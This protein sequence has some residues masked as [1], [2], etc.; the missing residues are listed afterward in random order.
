MA[1]HKPSPYHKLLAVL[2]EGEQI[3]VIGAGNMGRALLNGFHAMGIVSQ[4]RIV[5]ANPSIRR[6]VVRQFKVASS[7]LE[8]VAQRCSIIILAIKPQD[9]WPVVAQLRNALPIARV[10]WPLVISIAAG[11]RIRE[12]ESALGPCPVVRVM[13]NLAAKVGKAM[14]ALAGGRY[15][16]DLTSASVIFSGVGKVVEVPERL[17]DAVTA[18][19]GSG[20]AYF[21]T[22]FRA[23]RKA[24][25][26]QGLD[27]RTA[28]Q[29]VLQ[30]ALGSA[31]LTQHL[32]FERRRLGVNGPTLDELIRQVAS[33]GGTTEAALR[34]FEKRRLASILGEGVAA[35]AR[36]SRELASHMKPPLTERSE[37]KWHG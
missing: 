37:R 7:T 19:S 35:A 2:L 4:C 33:K 6:A 13:P 29:L 10:K 23:L 32:M 30:T 14:S 25:V 20:P 34:V 12:L 31:E 5:E 22:I 28:E 9:L 24:G 17:F 26:Q 18:I 21:F 36:R 3:G 11:V 8:Q 1:K 16:K 15:A 27:R